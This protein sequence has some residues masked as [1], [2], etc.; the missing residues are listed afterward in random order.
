MPSYL[1]S[2]QFQHTHS[3]QYR[4]PRS[5]SPRDADIDECA[6]Q[7]DINGNHCHLNTRCVNQAGN[8]TC[9]CLPGFGRVDT[10]NCADVDECRTGQHACPANAVCHNTIG[11]YQC[12]CRPGYEQSAADGT[13]RRECS[14]RQRSKYTKNC[15]AWI[16]R[17]ILKEQSIEVELFVKRFVLIIPETRTHNSD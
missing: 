4:L 5:L 17:Y 14:S 11:A 10:F 8:Y 9:E 2:S 16:R 13:C 7:G 6:Q 3:I 12:R 1:S 15:S